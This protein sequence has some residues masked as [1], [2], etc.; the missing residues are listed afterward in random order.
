MISVTGH[1]FIFLISKCYK[2]RWQAWAL[3][4]ETYSAGSLRLVPLGAISAYRDLSVCFFCDFFSLATFSLLGVGKTSVGLAR[5][6][7]ARVPRSEL[8]SPVACSTIG[9]TYS[10]CRIF[11]S[12]VYGEPGFY[13][14]LR[15]SFRQVSVLQ[16]SSVLGVSLG[17]PESSA[18]RKVFPMYFLLSIEWIAGVSILMCNTGK[19]CIFQ[20]YF[21]V[22]L[23]PWWGATFYD[24]MA[25]MSRNTLGL[26]LW[27]L[28][29]WGSITAWTEYCKKKDMKLDAQKL[30]WSIHSAY[31]RFKRDSF[32]GL[33]DVQIKTK[34]HRYTTLP[35]WTTKK[36]LPTYLWCFYF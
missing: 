23:T 18:L 19:Y 26:C 29:L 36:H 4:C 1:L 31:F 35:P 6:A 14:V 3:K 15:I 22:F 11:T 10:F 32:R 24:V 21:Q 5:A 33:S 2:Y 27:W 12:M 16:L 7:F 8:P 30:M 20:Q 34:L 25:K 13:Q 9:S 17:L 28:D